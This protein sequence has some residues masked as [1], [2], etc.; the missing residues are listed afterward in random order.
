MD[1]HDDPSYNVCRKP[2]IL[3]F[4]REEWR[5]IRVKKQS[6]WP[7]V[8]QHLNGKE[9]QNLHLLSLHHLSLHTQ[10]SCALGLELNIV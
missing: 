9:D 2:F 1:S 10:F 6:D 8:T 5:G 4:C 3:S 7:K